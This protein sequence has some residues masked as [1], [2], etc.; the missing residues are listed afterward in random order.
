MIKAVVTII[1][2]IFLAGAPSIGFSQTASPAK[3]PALIEAL[4]NTVSSEL[5]CLCGCNTTIKLCPHANCGFATPARKQI[6][7]LL[8]TGVSVEEIKSQFVE[9]HGEVILAKPEMK[10]FNLVG[11]FLPFI[12]IL[13][14]AAGLIKLASF[15]TRKGQ[16][17]AVHGSAAG[18]PSSARREYSSRL[19]QELA[20]FDD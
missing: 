8:A 12:V 3:D 18:E 20:E 17:A 9:R 10:G 1:F 16:E 4:Y 14:V 19:E 2:L 7:E 5:V 13:V 11:Y 15:W 6:R